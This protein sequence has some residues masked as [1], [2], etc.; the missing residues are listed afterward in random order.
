MALLELISTSHC[1]VF[2]YLL[3]FL[4]KSQ[5]VFYEHTNYFYGF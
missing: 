1:L 4:T 3:K 5:K 2:H